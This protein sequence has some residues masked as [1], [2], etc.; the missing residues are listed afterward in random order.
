M[1]KKS[2]VHFYSTWYS[3]PMLTTCDTASICPSVVLLDFCSCSDYPVPGDD[4]IAYYLR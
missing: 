3:G 2:F 4:A 1:A